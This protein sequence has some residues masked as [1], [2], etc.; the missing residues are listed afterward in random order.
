MSAQSLEL[1]GTDN[2]LTLKLDPAEWRH[3]ARDFLR[4][5]NISAATASSI[6]KLGEV[7]QAFIAIPYENLSKIIKFNQKHQDADLLRLPDEVWQDFRR[8]RLGGTCFSLTFFLDAVLHELGFT[9]YP[10]MARMNTGP[11]RHCALIILH[12][13]EHYLVDPGYVLDV[14]LLLKKEG[15]MLHRSAHTG[16]IVSP[17]R[18]DE[19]FDVWTF[20]RENRTWRYAFRDVPVSRQAFLQH[21]LDS[22]AWN[23]M[24]ALCLTRNQ[25]DKLIYIRENY[26]RETGLEGKRQYY[27]EGNRE[28]IIEQVFGIPAQVIE[29]ADKALE[30]LRERRGIPKARSR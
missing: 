28:Q 25:R 7:L 30:Q 3:T 24:N 23:G 16:V 9:T 19:T 21:W 26:F 15:A 14:P 6:D 20:N 13:G 27:M 2:P 1:P 22:F 11:N 8:F 5:Y 12:E 18:E 10:V 17:A 4:Y 29:E